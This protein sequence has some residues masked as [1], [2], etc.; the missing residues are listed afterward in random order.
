VTTPVSEFTHEMA[1]PN[2]KD[3][4]RCFKPKS[5]NGSK[6]SNSGTPVRGTPPKGMRRQYRGK[7]SYK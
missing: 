5:G 1:G 3:K 7:T 4:Y 6:S 2:L